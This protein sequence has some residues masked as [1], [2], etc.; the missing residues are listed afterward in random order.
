MSA[1]VK[2]GCCRKRCKAIETYNLSALPVVGG[3][4]ANIHTSEGTRYSS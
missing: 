3:S 4:E 2:G 1:A